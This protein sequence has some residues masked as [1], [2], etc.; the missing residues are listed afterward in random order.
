MGAEVYVVVFTDKKG[1]LKGG[2]SGGEAVRVFTSRE[3]LN[4]Y[5]ESD[6]WNAPKTV[7]RVFAW[8]SA[9]PDSAAKRD[10]EVWPES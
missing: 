10:S 4:T 5:L 9:Y 2:E 7:A 6:A 3:E 8:K 1:L